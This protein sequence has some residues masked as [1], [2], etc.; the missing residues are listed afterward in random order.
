VRINFEDKSFV[1]IKQGSPG[2]IAIILGA[3]KKNNI[4]EMEINACEL[5]IGQFTEIINN[6]GIDFNK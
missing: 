4:L 1:E 2:K 6:L 3:K 5:E